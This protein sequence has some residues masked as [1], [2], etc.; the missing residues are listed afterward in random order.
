MMATMWLLANAIKAGTWSMHKDV[1]SCFES[2]L[3][4]GPWQ[5]TMELDLHTCHKVVDMFE[6]MLALQ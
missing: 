3:C 1:K 6:M 4:T 2:R 5:I